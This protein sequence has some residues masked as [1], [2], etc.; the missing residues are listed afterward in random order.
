M[1]SLPISSL[2]ICGQIL[3]Q[4]CHDLTYLHPTFHFSLF[5]PRKRHWFQHRPKIAGKSFIP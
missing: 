5:C 4:G 3:K 1:L 2:A